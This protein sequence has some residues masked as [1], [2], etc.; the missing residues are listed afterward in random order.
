MISPATEDLLTRIEQL[1]ES[2]VART[3]SVRWLTVR[4]AAD[5]SGLGEKSIRRLLV[6]GKLT[7]HR[8]VRGKI[9]VCRLELDALIQASTKAIRRSRGQV[10]TV[11]Q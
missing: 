2:L 5:Y 4:A 1:L 10:G 8:P 11:K 6:G 3:G 9:L 7:A